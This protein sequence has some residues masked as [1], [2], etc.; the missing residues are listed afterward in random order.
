MTLAR[1]IHHDSPHELRGHGEK[2]GPVLPARMGLVGKLKIG[3]V[4]QRGGL[5]GVPLSFAAHVMVGQAMQLGLHQRNQLI[6]RSR[7]SLLQSP[8]SCVTCSCADGRV[9]IRPTI[10]TLCASP[11]R[12]HYLS[13][14]R[15]SFY[16]GNGG[17]WPRLPLY[18]M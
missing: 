9:A 1:V 2:V 8:R 3:L 16:C 14:F 10:L 5:Q 12:T 11:S 17:F 4:D 15:R 7:V 6:E 18:E 13:Q